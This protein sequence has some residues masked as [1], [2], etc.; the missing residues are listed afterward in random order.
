MKK[1]LYITSILITLI[2]GGCSEREKDDGVKLLSFNEVKASV[3][4]LPWTRTHLEDN[5]SM[6][7]DVVDAIGVFS[8]IQDVECFTID[9]NPNG[10]NASFKGNKMRGSIFYAYFPYN[11]NSYNGK[12]KTTLRV[13]LNDGWTGDNAANIPMVAVSTN[14]TFSFKQV[15]GI[16][17]IFLSGTNIVNQLTLE[18]NNGEYLAGSGTIDLN[19]NNP[20]IQMSN[21]NASKYSIITCR[22]ELNPYTPTTYYF[23]VPVIEF[24]NGFTLTIEGVNKQTNRSFSIKK[25]TEKEIN[26]SRAMIHGFAVV[27]TDELLPEEIIPVTEDGNPIV[28]GENPGKIDLD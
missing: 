2:I 4:V 21:S 26:I 17:K 8:D 16:I 15:C 20:I 23:P 13:Q 3:E 11:S 12:D 27:D 24:I 18:G 7:W 5:N 14:S 1:V 6:S 9:G 22:D 10:S 19:N 28:S 25:S